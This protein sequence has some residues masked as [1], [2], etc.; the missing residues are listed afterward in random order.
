MWGTR[1]DRKNKDFSS[2]VD[3]S[4][5]CFFFSRPFRLDKISSITILMAITIAQ[6]TNNWNLF[7]NRSIRAKSLFIIC[8]YS[9]AQSSAS[10]HFHL[11]YYWSNEKSIRNLHIFMKKGRKL[12]KLRQFITD[13]P[14]LWINHAHPTDSNS[15]EEEEVEAKN[16]NNNK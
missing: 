15:T 14:T 1:N 3:W 7:P 12:R 4:V 13:S 11:D 9:V 2:S 16:K 6:F 10:Y 5:G 8:V